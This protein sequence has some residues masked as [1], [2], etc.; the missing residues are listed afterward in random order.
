MSAD[1]IAELEEKA[2]ARLDRASYDY[3]AGG[4][5]DEL[6][7]AANQAAWARLELL[8]HVL[9]DVA[10]VDTSTTVVGVPVSAPIIIAPSAMH[11][12][13]C[14]EAEAA[15]AQAAGA[16]GT[17]MTLSLAANLSIE[18][19]AAAAPD[20]P[21]W[22]QTYLHRDRG[23]TAELT[24]RAAAAGFKAI[25]LTVD[26]PVLSRRRRDV[27][28]GF[29]VPAHL[30][31]PNMPPAPTGGSL[32]SDLMT[33]AAEFDP[34]VTFDDVKLP[35]DWCGLP[36][37]VK[38]LVRGDDARRA[39]DNGASGVIVSNHGGRELDG[40]IAT[41]RALP[42]VAEAVAGTGAVLV[43]GG[44]RS[45]TDVLRALALGA[46]AVLVGRPI[47]WGLANG[48]RQG[49]VDVL[50][51]LIDEFARAMALCGVV[52]VKEIDQDLVAR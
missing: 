50:Q 38:G 19:V 15:T 43:D 40:V 8:P 4:A 47:I 28:N 12:L 32:D 16:V 49:A 41:A 51:L 14:D 11:G 13:V 52:N 34:S 46:D 27:R 45:G 44:I 26:S 17:A 1:D 6:T 29:S 21:K 35:T 24:R 25:V 10:K 36:V 18:A 48:G 33:L 37:I 20:T 2:R 39:I 9:R 7:V 3:I 30:E 23:F 5:D 42:A 22:F 31:V